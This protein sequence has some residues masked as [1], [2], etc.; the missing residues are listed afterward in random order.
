MLTLKVNK[1]LKDFSLDLDIVLPENSLVIRG[2]S[3]SG[4]TTLLRCIAGL[5]SMPDG[6]IRFGDTVFL[7]TLKK[8]WIPPAQRGIGFAFQNYLLFP[9]LNV[10]DN[11][12]Y[13]LRSQG[14]GKHP[15]ELKPLVDLIDGLELPFSYLSR[16]PRELSGGEKQRVSLARALLAGRRLL[17]MDE[18][19]NAIDRKCCCRLIDYIYAWINKHDTMAIIVSHTEKN[20]HV[21]ESSILS[22][23]N[24]RVNSFYEKGCA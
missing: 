7:D 4:K 8:I 9:H 2:P 24:G 3:G 13:S 23:E 11:I 20:L 1:R 19:F 12:L 15:V 21:L 17:L 18:P 22:L 14:K 6:F 5:E 16:Y 10:K